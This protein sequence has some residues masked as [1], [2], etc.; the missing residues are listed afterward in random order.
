MCHA[1]KPE[2]QGIK[3]VEQGKD[4]DLAAAREGLQ[5][6]LLDLDVQQAQRVQASLPVGQDARVEAVWPPGVCE[7]HNGHRLR[8]KPS[9]WHAPVG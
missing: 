4:Q 8:G 6:G 9:L 2:Q 1:Q 3:N 5:A 7:E